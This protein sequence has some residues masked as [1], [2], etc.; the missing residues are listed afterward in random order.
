MR[1]LESD[2]GRTLVTLREEKAIACI[3]GKNT[4]A[5]LIGPA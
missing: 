1:L 3:L 5:E 4:A 2:C